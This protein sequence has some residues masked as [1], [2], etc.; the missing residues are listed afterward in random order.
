MLA[1]NV[2]LLPTTAKALDMASGLGGNAILMAKHHLQVEAWDISNIALE[3]LN[4]YSRANHLN[5]T[6]KL[7]DIENNPP[8]K[9]YF[10]V[11]VVTQFLHR[12]T[13]NN[14]IESLI[15]GGLLIYQTFCIEKVDNI[16]PS[17][18]NYL[19]EKNE[20]L[21]LCRDMQILVY[22]E[23]GLQGNTQ[24]GWRNQAMV[25]AKK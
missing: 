6:T 17:N 14:L 9:N 24:Q 3:K 2:H 23:E 8:E 20:L 1:E 25:I 13:F 21:H 19:L 11:I 18:P 22:R 15:T 16:G 10:N 7:R 12:P 4:E 5:I